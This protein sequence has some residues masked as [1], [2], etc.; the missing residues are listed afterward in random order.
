[1]DGE[2][3]GWVGCGTYEGDPDVTKLQVTAGMLT[4]GG[5]GA[6]SPASELP[7]TR[8]FSLPSVV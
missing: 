7:F 8:N 1:L 2:W 4:C 3:L 5:F 6:G